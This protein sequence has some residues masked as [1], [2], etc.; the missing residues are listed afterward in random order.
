[1]LTPQEIAA[2]AAALPSKKTSA[3]KKAM[4]DETTTNVDVTVRL[5]GTSA[6]GKQP[7]P[8][9]A[10]HRTPWEMAIARSMD[11]ALDGTERGGDG[12]FKSNAAERRVLENFR[13]LLIG[14]ASKWA[15]EDIAC[16]NDTQAQ[17]KLKK[18]REQEVQKGSTLKM[19][20]DMKAGLR[21]LMPTSQSQAAVSVAVD[22]QVIDSAAVRQ[23]LAEAANT[24]KDEV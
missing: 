2:L 10:T 19:M 7:A 5:V 12:K 15:R 13:D 22:V 6:K 21:K 8:R 17:R 16:G 23:G 18:A 3:A 11:E 20:A 9:Q 1:M 14:T 4:E 24:E